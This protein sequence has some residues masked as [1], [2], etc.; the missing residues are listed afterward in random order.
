MSLDIGPIK[1][2]DPVFLAPMSGVTDQPFRKLVK[3]YGAGLVFSEMIASR[4]M[5]QQGAPSFKSNTDY[6]EECPIAVQLAGCEP[7]VMAEAAK[8]N[9]GRGAAI[10]DINFGCP[11]KKIVNSY[12]GSALM[13]DEMLAA[14]IME[15]TVKAV[16]VPVTVKMRLGWNEQSINAPRLARI[17]QDIGIRMIT[18]HGRTRN[19]MYKGQADWDAVSAVKKAVNIPVIVNGDIL[20]PAEALRAREASGADGVMIGRGAYG[21]PWVIRQTMDYFRQGYTDTNPALPEIAALVQEHYEDMLHHYGRHLGVSIARK[22]LS[23]YCSG[24]HGA[25]QLRR[26]INKEQD[27]ATVRQMMESYFSQLQERVANGQSWREQSS[28]PDL[29]KNEPQNAE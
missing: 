17:A 1:I 2:D 16:D 14:K 9:V 5:L 12:A 28:P 26:D 21:K 19:Q 25:N 27:P 6:R 11:V 15:H 10:I 29:G 23:W 24:L 8:I 22:H 7:D 4:L 3:R 18:V 20:G 13:R